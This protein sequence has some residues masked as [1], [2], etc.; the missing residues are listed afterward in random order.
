MSAHRRTLEQGEHL[1]P[2]SSETRQ[3]VQKRQRAAGE[4]RNVFRFECFTEKI[5]QLAHLVVVVEDVLLLSKFIQLI[6]Y[7]A[8]CPSDTIGQ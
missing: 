6:V 5:I 1:L 4:K 3:I 8:H 7:V 2:L